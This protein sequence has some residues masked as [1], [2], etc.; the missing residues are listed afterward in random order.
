MSISSAAKIIISVKK[1]TIDYHTERKR[2]IKY[3][4]R[5]CQKVGL[6]KHLKMKKN[7]VNILN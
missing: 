6:F 7:T 4:S 1:R 3:I 2:K 5:Y